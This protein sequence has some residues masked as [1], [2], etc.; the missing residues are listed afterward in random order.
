MINVEFTFDDE[1]NGWL[2][3][4][5]TIERQVMI[6]IELVAVA[7]LVTLKQEPDGEY[8]VYGQSPEESDQYETKIT[9][10]EE[11]VTIKLA[12]PVEVK[13]CYIMN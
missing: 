3:E 11:E 7:P 8:A 2:S 10:S 6:H 5:L 9:T 4:P 13:N 12:T 1:A